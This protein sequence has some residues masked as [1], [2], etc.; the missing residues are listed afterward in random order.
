VRLL[1]L[2]LRSRAVPATVATLLGC[3]VAL[4]TLGLV[5]HSTSGRALAAILFA[6]AAS[7]TIA[8]GLAGPDH[9]LDKTAAI[10][11]PLRR[12]GHLFVACATVFGLLASTALVGQHMSHPGQL[13]RNAAGL[14]GLVALGAVVLGAARAPLTPVLWTTIVLWWTPPIAELPT[15]PSYKVMLTWMAQPAEARPAM[16]TAAGLAAIGTIAYAL[17]GS[18]R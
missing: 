8:H 1:V 4:W 11:W 14:A 17:L 10:G 15:R 18:R 7:T 2:Y 6:T 5:I 9:D 13:A 3:A 16:V 12:A